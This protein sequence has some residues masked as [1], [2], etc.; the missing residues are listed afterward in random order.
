MG[1]R[2]VFNIKQEDEMY[3]CLY[4]HW[5]EYT[6]L[7]E[8]ANA[9]AKARNRWVDESYCTRIIISQII[10]NEWDSETGYGLWAS[11]EPFTD[12]EWVLIDLKEKTITARDGSHTFDGFV[13]YHATRLLAEAK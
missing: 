3:V 2:V 8:L 4:S 13:S 1:A 6:A 12:E 9:L 7:E 11:T 10:G 5:G